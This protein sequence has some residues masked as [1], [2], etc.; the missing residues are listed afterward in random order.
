MWIIKSQRIF[1]N[2]Y[3][4]GTYV[5]NPFHRLLDAFDSRICQFVNFD[6]MIVNEVND[7]TV[8]I[9]MKRGFAFKFKSRLPPK[10]KIVSCVL[11][12]VFCRAIRIYVPN[13]L[14]SD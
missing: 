6:C 7:T 11:N 13:F 8:F 5:T 10:I 1:S 12:H 9:C 14:T 2:D 3:F 4:N